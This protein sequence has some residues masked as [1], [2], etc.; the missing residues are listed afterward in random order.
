MPDVPDWLIEHENAAISRGDRQD[1]E[2]PV[3][4]I[5][6]TTTCTTDTAKQRRCTRC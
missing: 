6:G 4:P 3:C 1:D 2:T 5:S